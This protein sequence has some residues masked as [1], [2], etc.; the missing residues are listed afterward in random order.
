M[1]HR[2]QKAL[3]I[4]AVLAQARLLA[5]ARRAAELLLDEVAAHLDAVRRGAVRRNWRWAPRPGSP[6]RTRRCSRRS[7]TTRNSCACATRRSPGRRTA[8]GRTANGMSK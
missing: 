7:A 6:A 3:L 5:A 1:L 8:A 2:E 4:A